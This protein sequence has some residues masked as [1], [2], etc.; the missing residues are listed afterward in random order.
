MRISALQIPGPLTGA[1]YPAPGESILLSQVDR[2]LVDN[3]PQ[4]PDGAY[5]LGD[6]GATI[7]N[8]SN[9]DFLRF[10]QRLCEIVY[11][12]SLDE[13]LQ[14]VRKGA[15]RSD[16]LLVSFFYINEDCK[17]LDYSIAGTMLIDFELCLWKL[18][19]WLTLEEIELL[20]GFEAVL[21]ECVEFKGVVAF[22]RWHYKI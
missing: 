19:K 16:D 1:Y 11:G 14:K 20:R 3:L 6:A 2:K 7:L 17:W 22:S 15:V 18:K 8:I 12:R 13:L 9:A 21:T 5:E 4:F 10:Q